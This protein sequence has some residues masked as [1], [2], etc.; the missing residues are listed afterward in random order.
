MRGSDEDGSE[1]RELQD[2][3]TLKY[4]KVLTLEGE[5]D[6]AKRQVTTCQG[7]IIQKDE[8]IAKLKAEMR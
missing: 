7:T 5:L 3:L 2:Q 4:H 6:F 8:A 1:L